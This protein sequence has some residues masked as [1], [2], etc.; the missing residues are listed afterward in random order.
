MTDMAI[1]WGD[2]EETQNAAKRSF[3]ESIEEILKEKGVINLNDLMKLISH[4]NNLLTDFQR[5]LKGIDTLIEEGKVIID[6][7]KNIRM[8]TLSVLG[9][10]G[11]DELPVWDMLHKEE[12]I[13]IKKEIIRRY[14]QINP[15]L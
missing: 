11:L 10:D 6:Q 2:T 3:E 1:L 15:M 12:D 9:T 14:N 5:I 7:E 8:T 4:D 13:E